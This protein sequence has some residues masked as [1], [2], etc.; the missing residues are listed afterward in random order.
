MNKIKERYEEVLE[1]KF[2]GVG[3]IIKKYV[4]VIFGANMGFYIKEIIYDTEEEAT[5]AYS[6]LLRENEMHR[7]DILLTIRYCPSC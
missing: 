1:N 2:N 5:I 7:E 4:I 6:M 3:G